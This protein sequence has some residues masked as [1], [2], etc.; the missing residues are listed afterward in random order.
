MKKFSLVNKSDVKIGEDE[1]T[2]GEDGSIGEDAQLTVNLYHFFSSH[3]LSPLQLFLYGLESSSFR[4]SKT[5]LLA[6]FGSDGGHWRF[7]KENE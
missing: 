2:H 7:F 6:S 5:A 4:L 1:H 3:E